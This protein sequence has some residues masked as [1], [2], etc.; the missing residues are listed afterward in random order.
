[1]SAIAADRIVVPAV[2]RGEIVTTDLIRVDGR[3]AGASFSVPDPSTLLARLPLTDPSRLGE[4]HDLTF[5]EIV[6]FLA[7]VGR[8]LTLTTNATLQ[9]ALHHAQVLSDQ[10]PPLVRAAF[11]GLPQLFSES[12]VSELADTT[13]GIPYLEGWV[14]QRMADSRI[15]AI[16]AMGARTVHIVAGNSPI[17]SALSVVRNAVLRSDAIIKA[18]SNDPLTAVAIARAMVEVDAR[19]PISRHLAVCYWKGGDTTIEAELYRPRNIEKIIAWGG[20]AS[21]THVQHYVTPGLE[22]IALDPKRSATIIGPEA[23]ADEQTVRDVA[24]RA[25]TDVGALNQ[26]GCVNARVIYAIANQHEADRLGQLVYDE[27]QRLPEPV[28]TP[29]RRFDPDLRASIDGLRASP[30]FYKVIGGMHDEGAVIVS[31]HDEPVDFHRGL[32]DRVANIVPVPDVSEVLPRINASTQTIGVYPESLK[33]ELRDS[34]ALHGAQ[35]VVSLGYA[36]DPNVALPQDAFEPMRRMARWIVD[37]R[38][39]PS[40]TPP[41]WER[42]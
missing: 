30:D 12:T 18:P 24:R 17:I 8:H 27:L 28:S 11:E 32:R 26:L 14:E 23:F 5:D 37:E 4:L 25:A 40:I 15:A 3:S 36:A 9:E 19:H 20:S 33:T 10:T 7:E 31:Q 29:A 6:S 38:C 1:M 39:D 42:T 35:R 21:V 41:L 2:L 34:L 16:R 22:L 13:I